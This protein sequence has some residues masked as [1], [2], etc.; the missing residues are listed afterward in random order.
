MIYTLAQSAM[1]MGDVVAPYIHVF[2]AA[3]IVAF[4]FTPLMQTV[5]HHYGIIDRPDNSRKVH[6]TAVAYLGGIAVFLGW[7]TGLAVS[8]F[9]SVHRA[10]PGRAPH[11][12][13]AFG[14]IAGASLI[15]LLG[16]WDDVKG[17]RPLTKIVGQIAAAVMLLAD[18]IGTRCAQSLLEP[19]GDH[20]VTM[21]S[22]PRAG[23][24]MHAS[25]WLFGG[26][27]DPSAAQAFPDWFVVF[28]SSALVVAVVVGCCNAANLMD[29]L[30][31]LCGGVTAVVSGGLL[32]I[33]VHLA[34][35]GRAENTGWDAMRIVLALAL[36]GGVLG[37]IPF[38]FNPASIFMGD[39]GSM[40]LG[41]SCATLIIL[42][43]QGQHPQWFLAGLIIF[44][45]PVLDTTL[46]FA[47]RWVAGRPFFSADR[48]HIHHQLVQRGFTVK[49]TVLISYGLA[50]FFALLGISLVYMRLRFAGAI[51]IVVFGCIMVAAFKMG[52]VHERVEAVKPKGLD[53]A[54]AAPDQEA[55]E[56]PGLVL[57]V[58]TES[59]TSKE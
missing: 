58:D 28:V 38:N 55:L 59:P 36:L 40:F 11:V 43:G 50:I 37:F 49:Q 29:G 53:D 18:G 54:G 57:R 20:L 41:F 27:P 8:Q 19:I 6:R 45:L 15:V 3:F 23:W 42:M 33:A 7:L 4:V 1:P 21:L 26:W 22:H 24:L 32:F 52:M 48:H 13:I 25:Q 35:Q 44:A 14:V 12:L 5:A 34:S 17:V 39:T 47:R 10:D 9:L 51:Y 31:G 56:T 46:A 2:Y 30:D 16:L